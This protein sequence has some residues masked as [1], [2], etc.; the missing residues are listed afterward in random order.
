MNNITHVHPPSTTLPT[1]TASQARTTSLQHPTNLMQLNILLIH[2]FSSFSFSRFDRLLLQSHSL[3][4][5]NPLCPWSCKPISFSSL[6]LCLESYPNKHKRQ[7]YFNLDMHL[8]LCMWMYGPLLDYQLTLL[9][10]CWWN[11]SKS[12]PMYTV[13]GNSNFLFHTPWGNKGL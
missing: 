4:Y 6:N 5:H 11:R 10:C 8:N 13:I 12:Q 3:V 1:T 9:R 2:C 7:I